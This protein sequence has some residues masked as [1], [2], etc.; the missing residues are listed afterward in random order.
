MIE[1]VQL[2][3]W[4][5]IGKD[6]TISELKLYVIGTYTMIYGECNISGGLFII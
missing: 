6:I 3:I 2:K 4:N 5:I 1:V